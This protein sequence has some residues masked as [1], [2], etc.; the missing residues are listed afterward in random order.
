MTWEMCQLFNFFMGIY[1]KPKF[2]SNSLSLTAILFIELDSIG[3]IIKKVSIKSDT[4]ICVS[5]FGSFIYTHDSGYC[6]VGNLHTTI[7]KYHY[8]FGTG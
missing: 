2:Y 1:Q 4:I 7:N 5:G 8:F 6:F 3:N